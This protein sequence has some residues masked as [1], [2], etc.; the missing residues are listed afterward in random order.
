MTAIRRIVVVLG[1]LLPLT[2]CGAYAETGKAIDADLNHARLTVA[3]HFAGFPD[4]FG[5]AP[6]RTS[7]YVME[8]DENGL[9][10]EPDDVICPHNPWA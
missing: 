4:G 8:F 5:D 3:F 6:E 10:A 9:M 7:C 1:A 2:A